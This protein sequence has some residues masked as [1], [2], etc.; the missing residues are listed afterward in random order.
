MAVLINGTENIL[1]THKA[2]P[3]D[4]GSFCQADAQQF[5]GQLCNLD[6][7]NWS[8]LKVISRKDIPD[9]RYQGYPA[10]SIC[11]AQ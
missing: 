1:N 3:L 11:T 10:S 2:L 7:L 8:N 9:R 4:P 5:K 6:I